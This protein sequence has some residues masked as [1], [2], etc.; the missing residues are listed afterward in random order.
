MP[1]R[2]QV[3]QI[4]VGALNSKKADTLLTTQEMGSQYV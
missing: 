2:E 3:R 4:F 1:Q